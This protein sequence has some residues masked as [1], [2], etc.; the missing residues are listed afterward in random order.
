M[1][2]LVLV[3]GVAPIAIT[4]AITGTITSAH[5]DPLR[6]EVGKPLQKAQADLRKRDF[7]AATRDVNQA[8]AVANKTADESY[9]VAQMRA[10][11]A[12]SS[13]NVPDS[14][15]AD[16][17]LIASARTPAAEK[18][19]LLMAEAGLAYQAKD[20]ASAETALQRYFKAGGN[21][22]TMHTLLIQSYYL[23]KNFPEA[24]KAQ[25]RQIAMEEKAG[26]KPTENQLNLLAS[27][28]QQAN[29]P[30]GFTRTMIELVKY[31]PKPNYWAQ[32]IHG[33]QTN[34][35][36]PARLQYDVDRIR[37]AVGLLTSANDL[38]DMAELATEQGYPVQ[39]Q[40]ALAYGYKSGV[41]GTGPGAPR[42]AKLKAFIDQAAA[43]RKANLD[44]D[45]AA[46]KAAP[47]G[48]QL[49]KTGYNMVDFGQGPAGIAAIQQGIA[50]GNLVSVDDAKL[51]LGLAQ[52]DAGMKPDAIRTLQGVG[53]TDG[54]ADLA[55]LWI[56]QLSK[57]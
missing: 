9:T 49:I 44:K 38:V 5:A 32:L 19:R 8:D 21:D 18:I 29:D 10:A 16:D 52:A 56:L 6:P 50:K 24:A 12:Q 7:A 1:R 43:T 33:L 46:A 55:Q 23:Q 27:V 25:Q 51:T 42:Q 2:A 4:G 34:P 45:L 48:S 17:A 14:I 30:N 37:F 26:Q 57:H 3:A 41:L 20:Y 54:A 36:I 11:V 28:Q 40:Q 39:G 31:Y 53:G 22:P 15:R 35:N 13:G 47:D